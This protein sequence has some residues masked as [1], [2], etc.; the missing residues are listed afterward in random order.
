M[1]RQSENEAVIWDTIIL[2]YS[3]SKLHLRNERAKYNINDITGKFAGE[4]ITLSF[5][6]NVQPHVG[7]LAWGSVGL[8]KAF[9]VPPTE[10]KKTTRKPVGKKSSGPG[11]AY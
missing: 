4:N 10:V 5:H 6:W 8:S 7:V 2:S 3:V 11:G 9:T 1:T